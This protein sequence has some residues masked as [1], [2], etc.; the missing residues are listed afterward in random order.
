MHNDLDL[1]IALCIPLDRLWYLCSEEIV[2]QCKA[3]SKNAADA[4]PF[5]LVENS[6]P[7]ELQRF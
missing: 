7:I 2:C 6:N 5:G 4:E 3:H 1:V